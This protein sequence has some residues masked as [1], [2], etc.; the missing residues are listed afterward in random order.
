MSDYW[1][2][3]R[4]YT[5]CMFSKMPPWYTQP[6]SWTHRTH[7]SWHM[8][9]WC[10]WLLKLLLWHRWVLNWPLELLNI[11]WT[12]LLQWYRTLQLWSLWPWPNVLWYELMLL[13]HS[14]NTWHYLKLTLHIPKVSLISIT[15]ISIPMLTKTLK[16]LISLIITISLNSR[17]LPK[18]KSRVLKS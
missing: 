2:E 3:M 13:W 10:Q 18:W 15:S 5:S 8:P 11:R 9:L 1:P 7:W 17:R 4:F 14:T 6:N 16:F 12:N